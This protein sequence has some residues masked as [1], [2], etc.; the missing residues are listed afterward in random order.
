MENGSY[1]MSP[2]L[3]Y[4][5]ANL[6]WKIKT[7]QK[8]FELKIIRLVENGLC[9]STN[10]LVGRALVMKLHGGKIIMKKKKTNFDEEK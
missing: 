10:Q 7:I 1:F 8:P 4:H 6:I 2:A 9:W 5:A 3:N